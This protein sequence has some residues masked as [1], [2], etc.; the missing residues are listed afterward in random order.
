MGFG[1]GVE[2]GLGD[3]A[4][5]MRVRG[6]YGDTGVWSRYT[7]ELRVMVRSV[8]RAVQNPPAAFPPWSFDSSLLY[9][10]SKPR[11]PAPM[12]RRPGLPKLHEITAMRRTASCCDV[13]GQVSGSPAG[14]QSPENRPRENM[15]RLLAGR[16]CALEVDDF[17]DAEAK[18]FRTS[19]SFNDLMWDGFTPSQ[20]PSSLMP[21]V[22]KSR[23][24]SRAVGA[25]NTT[26]QRV[27]HSSV[28]GDQ[29]WCGPLVRASGPGARV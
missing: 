11:N 7:A 2:G 28:S 14:S 16:I 12:P 22:P 19:A 26:L 29:S 1:D 27:L 10:A 3:S 23:G 21:A 8:S 17:C 9:R 6:P 4:G 15:A 24:P 13:R 5:D 25:V 18:P 20:G